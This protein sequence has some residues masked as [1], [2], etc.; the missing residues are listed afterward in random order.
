MKTILVVEDEF[1]YRDI[2]KLRLEMEGYEVV[3]AAHGKEA[4][5]LLETNPQLTKQI[6]LVLLD[7]F[8]PYMT[9]DVF[10]ERIRE[11]DHM[12]DVP[13]IVL[14]NFQRHILQEKVAAYLIKSNVNLDQVVEQVKN[15]I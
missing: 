15:H 3:T 6:N 12:G 9:G 1:D 14:T 13:V 8:M 10:Y 2:L 5:E 4:L 7:L 11:R